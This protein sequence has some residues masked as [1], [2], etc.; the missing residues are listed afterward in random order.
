MTMPKRE[1][2]ARAADAHLDDLLR[3]EDVSG[4]APP[5]PA[6]HDR[7]WIAK[8]LLLGFAS[9]AVLY[10]LARVFDLGPPYPLVLAVCLGAVLV[11]QAAGAVAEPRWLKTASV[12]RAPSPERA[13]TPGGW[14]TGQDGVRDAVQRWA[15]RLDW[16]ASNAD[17]FSS[18]VVTRLGQL[19]DEVLRQ[20]H[21]LTRATDPARARELLGP[22][23]W[24]LLH[25]QGQ[26][27]PSA[28]DVA[29]AVQRLE[30]L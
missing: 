6:G 28:S 10:T 14:H 23:V 12:V 16:G 3:F 7:V 13:I 2:R 21:G 18:T 20:R 29:V 15:R 26:T 5:R 8:A 9:S 30:T 19:T 25:D 4:A 1:R 17:R 22:Q 11:R 24:K 27:V